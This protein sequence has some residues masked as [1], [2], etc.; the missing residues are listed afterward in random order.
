MSAFVDD[1][2]SV[3][4]TLQP[5]SPPPAPPQLDSDGH[6][7]V[8]TLGEILSA[9]VPPASP[10]QSKR[11]TASSVSSDAK[12][13]A[14]PVAGG[15]DGVS[16]AP[17]VDFDFLDSLANKRKTRQVAA[18]SGTAAPMPGEEYMAPRDNLDEIDREAD[19]TAT[20]KLSTL[21]KLRERVIAEEIDEP[22]AVAVGSGGGGGRKMSDEMWQRVMAEDDGDDEAEKPTTTSK[23]RQQQD[24]DDDV[25][26]QVSRDPFSY[27]RKTKTAAEIYLEERQQKAKCV[28]RIQQLEKKGLDCPLPETVDWMALPLAQLDDA[29]VLMETM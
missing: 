9:P 26:S 3:L 20:R 6:N 2:P 4:V 22:L 29:R 8:L 14:Q 12:S 1:D 21:H 25:R 11:S 24:D 7:R 10:A 5:P 27:T 17:A 19:K 15:H 28:A 23:R 13:L 18:K 16:S